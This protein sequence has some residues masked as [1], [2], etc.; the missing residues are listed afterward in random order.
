MLLVDLDQGRLIPD[1][2]LRATLSHRHPYR[3]WLERNQIVLGVIADFTARDVEEVQ[4]K[5]EEL[6]I[7]PV[8]KPKD[9]SSARHG[10]PAPPRS[11]PSSA[12]WP[13]DADQ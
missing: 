9:C 12:S 6:G 2:E 7:L 1:E 5:A 13:S 4:Q 10:L 11:T 8:W 3:Q